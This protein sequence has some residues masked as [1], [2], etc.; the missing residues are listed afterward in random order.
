MIIKTKNA[1]FDSASIFTPIDV[2]IRKTEIDQF[3]NKLVYVSDNWEDILDGINTDYKKLLVHISTNPEE[4]A[5]FITSDGEEWTF[6]LPAS[7]VKFKAVEP[8]KE[9]RP[10]ETETELFNTLQHHLGS[11]I[12][13]RNKNDPH[14]HYVGL[15]EGYVMEDKHLKSVCF[16]GQHFLPVDLFENYEWEDNY[17]KWHPFGVEITKE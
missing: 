15:I 9:Y 13:Y 17:C 12:T 3:V 1:E 6:C 11:T 14:T 2:V 4:V 8:K 7:A 10:F 16:A 5:P